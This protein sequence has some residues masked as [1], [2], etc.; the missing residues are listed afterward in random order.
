MTHGRWGHPTPKQ[1]RSMNF[2]SFCSK[3]KG[4]LAHFLNN[5]W[6]SILYYQMI[7]LKQLQINNLLEIVN[8]LI[9]VYQQIID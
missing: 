4:V 9:K 3:G 6:N 1:I 8:K 2:L 7:D 5:Y